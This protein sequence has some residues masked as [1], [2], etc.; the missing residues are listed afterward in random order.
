[1]R[2]ENGESAAG[3]PGPACAPP[4]L[5]LYIHIPFCASICGYCHFNRGLSDPALERRYVDAV[6]KEIGSASP[7]A[8]LGTAATAAADT[9]YLGGGTPSLLAPAG[10]ASLVGACRDA[11]DVAPDAEVTLEANPDTVSQDRL[12][13][14]RAAGINRLS[15]GVQSFRDSDLARLGRRHDAERARAAF[16]E[17]RAAGFDNISL[18][19]MLAL[20]G[21]ALS[22]A[23][24]SADALVSLEPEHASVYLLELYPGTPL[25]DAL[26]PGRPDRPDEDTAADLY[27]ATMER[28]EAAG[29]G[30]YEISNVA[31][32][33]RR[34]RHN[35]K[36]WT[37]GRWCGF[38]CGAHSTVGAERWDNVDS[39]GEYVSRI[40]GGRSPV[41]SRRLRSPREQVE[42]TLFMGLRLTDGVALD[43][44]LARHGVD[45]WREWGD[46]LAAFEEA[47]LLTREDRRLRLTRKGMLLATD[48]M[49][50]FLEAGSTLQ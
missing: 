47:G 27:L 18:D 29:Y 8:G 33:G 4:P 38:G 31:R 13:G 22:D 7:S 46:R 50:T 16:R 36:Y 44:V 2:I 45:V 20:P 34:S 15:F 26:A 37:D 9:I 3:N 28:L 21:Q 49:S 42:E 12:A 6:V 35:M 5:G 23:L 30:Q 43:R 40:E 1:M 14:Y 39:V 41:A 48:V 17:A 24:E 32:P 19:L 11:F 25:G 10:V